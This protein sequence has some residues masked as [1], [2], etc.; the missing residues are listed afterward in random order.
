MFSIQYGSAKP[1]A[2]A[3]VT[4][5]GLGPNQPFQFNSDGTYDPLNRPYTLKWTFGDGSTSTLVRL[6]S[7]LQ[8]RY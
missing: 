8:H 7:A 6:S 2:V 5:P 4:P 3:S 1:I